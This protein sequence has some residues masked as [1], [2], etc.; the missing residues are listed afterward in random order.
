MAVIIILNLLCS[1]TNILAI[2]FSRFK[3]CRRIGML[4]YSDSRLDD[5]ASHI[6]KLFLESYIQ[7]CIISILAL[8]EY[9]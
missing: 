1:I 5:I 7:L 2:V 8:C 9:I 4:A 3:F 6:S